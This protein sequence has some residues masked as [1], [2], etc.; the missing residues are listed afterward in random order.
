MRDMEAAVSRRDTIVTRGDISHKN[1]KIVT[2]G[3][4]QRDIIEI[5]RKI[6]ETTKVRGTKLTQSVM[7][8]FQLFFF[9]KETKKLE[10]DINTLQ[11][12]QDDLAT[13]LEQRQSNI[14]Q[15]NAHSESKEADIESLNRKKLEVRHSVEA[16]EYFGQ[17]RKSGLSISKSTDDLLTKQDKIKFY[18]SL[19][20]GKYK[21]SNRTEIGIEQEVNK[22]V[23]K[24]RSLNAII[25]KLTEEY[26]NLQAIIRRV[27]LSIQSRLNQEEDANEKI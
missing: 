22:Q 27:E 2:H 13:T 9:L 26:P 16:L 1:P 8:F 12:K 5:Q 3:K 7:F 4:I 17:M 15:L 20:D 18:N 25:N 21:M 10:A 23:D 11:L 14:Y 6:K 19:K 24:L